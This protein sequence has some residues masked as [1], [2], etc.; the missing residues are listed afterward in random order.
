MIG[1]MLVPNGY[2][3]WRGSTVPHNKN[4]T[5]EVDHNVQAHICLCISLE[6]QCKKEP[7]FRFQIIL[8]IQQ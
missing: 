1:Q 6:L 4:L 7:V 8:Q 2:P 5:L 3:Q